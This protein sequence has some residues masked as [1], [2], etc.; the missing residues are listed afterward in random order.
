MLK[1]LNLKMRMF[2]YIGTIAC[3]AFAVTIGVV[4]VKSG[5]MA[6][7]DAREKSVETSHRYGGIIKAEIEVAM[8]AARTLAQ[9]VEALKLSGQIPERKTMDQILKQLTAENPSFL[10][11]WMVWEPNALDN[12]DSAFANTTGYDATGRYAH[13]A[14][15]RGSDISIAPFSGYETKDYYRIPKSQGT[16]TVIEPFI[17]TVNGKKT[18]MTSLCV[19]MRHKGQIIG[20][21]GVSMAL[22]TIQEQFTKIR[23]FDTGYITVLSNTGIVVTHPNP[24]LLGKSA[25]QAAPWLNA[26]REN[27]SSGHSIF[28]KNQSAALGEE[29]GRFGEPVWVGNT[30]TPWTVMV[31]IPV[32]EA[33]KKANNIKHVSIG[34]GAAAVTALMLILYLIVNSITGPI[35]EGV[36]FAE[37]MATGDFS[38]TLEVRQY[39]EIGKLGNALNHMTS[40]IGG[41][42][43]EISSGV[44]TLSSSSTDLA[45]ISE[46]MTQGTDQASKKTET[47]AAATEE[48]SAS[49]TSIAV[50]MEQASTNVSMVAAASEEMTS[51]INEVARNTESA[52]SI[53]DTAVSQAKLAHDKIAELGTAAQE[54][55]K[56]TETISDISDQTNL[57]ALN[58]T[59]E[60]A[61][62]GEA[63]K[64]FA[65][66]ATEIKEL[67]RLTSEATNDIRNQI[68]GIQQATSVSVESI[69]EITKII[70][71]ISEIVSTTATAVEEQAATTQ[72]ISQN[73]SQAS[74]GLT[75]IN[76]NVAQSSKVAGEITS[77]ISEVHNQAIEMTESSSAVNMN[78]GELLNLAQKL[79]EMVGQFKV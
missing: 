35:K 20:V 31:N 22:E 41:M 68:G 8:A 27:I 49:M 66:V 51:T 9:T 38:Q 46:Q 75:E 32:S 36:R 24:D 5:N 44:E 67:A 78:A 30:N 40:N 72:E 74:Q 18:L 2:L 71:D 45:T 7:E 1:N 15:R 77:D 28:T 59:I 50:A 23:I 12:R 60:A 42:I 54:I 62:A 69:E 26:F 19:P 73:V 52:R 34:I 4:A 65:V 53:A 25:F 11:T 58:A 10:S 55:G 16:E 3:L 79:K 17:G 76:E 48:M 13:F 6:R 70:D 21:A 14:S 39:D 64:G 33:L 29:V 57:L 61:R 43:K 47:V 56:V 37:A 63:G